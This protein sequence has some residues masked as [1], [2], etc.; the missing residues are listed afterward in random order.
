MKKIHNISII[1]NSFE[2]DIGQGIDKCC[3]YL[4]DGLKD[5]DISIKKIRV[6][7]SNNPI[8][9]FFMSTF[10]VFFKLIFNNSNLYHFTLPTMAL[11]CLFKRP[12]IVT[13]YDLIPFVLKNERKKSYNLY[14]KF[15]LWFVKKADHII[16]ISKSTLSEVITYLN[17][18]PENITLI[19]PGVDHTFFFPKN[20]L[21]KT[22]VFSEVVSYQCLTEGI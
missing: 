7:I 18:S 9:T 8:Y 22:K 5:T 13:I 1:G 4:Y 11:P 2:K 16:V 12:S 17:V 19:Y 21:K 20:N 3:G 6:P 10:G 14:F 15:M